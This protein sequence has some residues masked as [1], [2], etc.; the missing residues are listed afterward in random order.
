MTKLRRND[1]ELTE[2]HMAFSAPLQFLHDPTDSQDTSMTT[3][4]RP[5]AILW[6]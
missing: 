3:I 5:G 4:V 2:R 6:P 1:L